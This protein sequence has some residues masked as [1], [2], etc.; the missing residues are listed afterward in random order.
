M[1]VVD[2][3]IGPI[4]QRNRIAGTVILYN[5]SVA[6]FD[7][8]KTYID[9]V[10]VLYVVDN[11]DRPNAELI[12][13]FSEIPTVEF[14]SNGGN[15]GVAHA[16]NTAAR[17]AIVDG[18]THLLTMDDDSKAPA[19][20]VDTMRK[21][22]DQYADHEKVGIISAVHNADPSP[23]IFR[24]V[25]Y[26]MTSGNLLDLRIYQKVGG[27]WEELFIDHVDHEYGLRLNDAGYQVIELLGLFLNHS[28]GESKPWSSW[29]HTGK[30]ISHKP[31]RMY[32]I[33]RNGWLVA[34]KHPRFRWTA[35]R[36]ISKEWIKSIVWENARRQRIHFLFKGMQH[37]YWGRTGKL[38]VTN[39]P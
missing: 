32:Y 25:P 11:S 38:N 31:S 1:N 16:L 23:A 5:S 36:L 3:R 4:L 30:F 8:I 33:A 2:S 14:M 15:K 34:K 13:R 26:T 28:L 21:F 18:F 12:S 7:N 10:E 19:R 20:M 24:I 22:L 29:F 17:Q 37:A 35:V 6:V 9:Q 27:F 39:N